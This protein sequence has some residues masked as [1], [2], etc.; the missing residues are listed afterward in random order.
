MCN[1]KIYEYFSIPTDQYKHQLIKVI[2]RYQN[3]NK[4]TSIRTSSNNE[5]E[6]ARNSPNKTQ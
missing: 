3:A 2:L 4:S 5:T 1:I 6:V